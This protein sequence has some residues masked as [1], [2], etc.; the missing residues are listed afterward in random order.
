MHAT[1]QVVVRVSHD[2]L[3]HLRKHARTLDVSIQW[4]VARL[5]CDTLEILSGP[6]K[7]DGVEWIQSFLRED[8]TKRSVARVA[9]LELGIRRKGTN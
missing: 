1:S 5:V 8:G 9:P 7:D 6:A 2:L 4:I 3:R